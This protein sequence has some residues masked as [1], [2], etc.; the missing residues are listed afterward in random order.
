M[1]NCRSDRIDRSFQ[2]ARLIRDR[3]PAD[4]YILTGT[5]TEIL[6]REL[7]KTL[8]G[9]KILDAGRKTPTDAVHTI[10]DFVAD[11][12]LI[13]AIGNTVGYGAELVENFLLNERKQ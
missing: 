4:N 3:L 7:H 11:D 1:V 6:S 12:S 10:A 5:G 13:F 9:E 8:E 2:M